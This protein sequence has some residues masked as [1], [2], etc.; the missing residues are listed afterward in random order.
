MNLDFRRAS[1]LPF[2]GS[3]PK[4]ATRFYPGARKKS[5]DLFLASLSASATGVIAT[6][7][8]SVVPLDQNVTTLFAVPSLV[9]KAVTSATGRLIPKR[10]FRVKVL[11]VL[12]S[13]GDLIFFSQEECSAFP[14]AQAEKR[15][16]LQCEKSDWRSMPQKS[17]PRIH[18]KRHEQRLFFV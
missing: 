3:F 1:S 4:G 6:T 17:D 10:I 7:N 16:P 5:F 18:T 11:C 12:F 14:L 15:K 9:S 13:K 8:R 2:G